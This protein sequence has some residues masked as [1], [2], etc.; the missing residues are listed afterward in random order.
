MSVVAEFSIY[1]IVA[2]LDGQSGTATV[3]RDM[4]SCMALQVRHEVEYCIKSDRIYMNG[5]SRPLQEM[6]DAS[7]AVS[8]KV[9]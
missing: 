4:K 7:K 2:T 9:R 3:M 8:K 6:L 5:D 1:L